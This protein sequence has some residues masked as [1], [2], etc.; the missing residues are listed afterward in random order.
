MEGLIPLIS[1][2]FQAIAFLCFL[3]R[4]I[5]FSFSTLLNLDE[6]ITGNLP[7]LSRKAYSKP[8]G[9]SLSSMGGFLGDSLLRGS[10]RSR[11]LKVCSMATSSSTKWSI[12]SLVSGGSSSSS[13]RGSLLPKGYFIE[14][15]RSMLLLNAPN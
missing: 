1:T 7:S 6:I 8:F 13:I 4:L 12:S 15:S 9:S 5:N 2:S 11:T 14:R 3:R 10:S